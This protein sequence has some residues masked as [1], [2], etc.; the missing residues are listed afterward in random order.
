MPVAEEVRQAAGL[1]ERRFA[2]TVLIA[3]H[4]GAVR[5]NEFLYAVN[6]IP[7]RT[8]AARLGE[9]ETA[10][11]LEREIVETRPPHFEYRLTERGRAL[12]ALV[13]ALRGWATVR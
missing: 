2:L 12:G 3:S 9:L 7:P 8:L 11:L 4:E 1:L 10:G 5:F 13:E 6:E